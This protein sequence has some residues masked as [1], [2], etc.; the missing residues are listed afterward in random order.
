MTNVTIFRPKGNYIWAAAALLL[1]VLFVVQ[2][3]FYPADQNLLISLGVALAAAA[4]AYLLW[5]RPKLEL[6]DTSLRVVNPTHTTVIAYGDIVELQTK[7]SLLIIHSGGST[8]VWVAP[9]SGRMRWVGGRIDNVARATYNLP[10]VNESGD[11][12]P[13]SESVSSDSGLA[14]LLIRRRIDQL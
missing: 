13:V 4:G 10:T 5:L 11:A 12:I 1:D 9:A 14:A 7:W 8:R 3:L 2:V 6:G